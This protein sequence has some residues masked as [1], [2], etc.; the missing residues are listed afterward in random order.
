MAN[1]L[2]TKSLEKKDAEQIQSPLHEFAHQTSSANPYSFV[3]RLQQSAGNQ[4]VSELLG[5]NGQSGGRPLTGRATRPQFQAKLTVSNP[6]DRYEVEA[7]RVA[8]QVMG[9]PSAQNERGQ[10][11]STAYVQIQRACA[12]CDE[13]P[14]SCCGD[15]ED[16][17]FRKAESVG[18]FDAN[19]NVEVALDS[20]RHEGEQLPVSV[21]SEMESRFGRD[22]S[23]VKIHTGPRAAAAARSVN[24]KAFTVGQN[25]VFGSGYYAPKTQDGGRLLAH[26]LTHVVQQGSGAAGPRLQRDEE[27]KEPAD[28]FEEVQKAVAEIE[29]NWKGVK[30]AASSFSQLSEW[31]KHGNTV[32]YL[33]SEHTKS[34]IKASKAGLSQSFQFYLKVL[35]SDKVMYDY[36]A[37]HVVVHANI[38]GLNPWLASLADS[39]KADDRQFTGRKEAEEYLDLLQKLAGKFDKQAEQELKQVSTSKTATGKSGD[40]IITST[41]ATSALGSEGFFEK[42][43]KEM[44]KLQGAIQTLTDELNKFLATAQKEGLKQVGEALVEF[45]LARGGGKGKGPKVSKPKPAKP[46]PKPSGGTGTK[47]EPAPKKEQMPEKKPQE[48]K[49]EEKKPEEKKKEEKKKETCATKYPGEINCSS[50]PSSYIYPTAAAALAALKLETGDD[51]LRLHNP[52]T[53]TGGPCPGIGTH[54]N[55]R[56][57]SKRIASIGCCPCCKD[58]P[59]G[60]VRLTLCR[61]I[62]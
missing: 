42:E 40:I 7:D 9:A 6:S 34:A 5:S 17:L 44:I 26:E 19:E 1:D 22:F 47:K 18:G 32:V 57:G 54:I 31:I 48:K 33:I 39:F 13:R 60:P 46:N 45:I 8:E 62:Y 35:E 36:I 3:L 51:H 59:A 15:Q 24:A 2:T 25:V 20:L 30:D 56:S 52:A 4:A 53:A 21:R 27:K 37:W 49:P 43:T 28:P 14:S 23:G 41:T 55:V 29:E 50:L 61:I 12:K 38:S 11:I 10:A 58:T 16:L